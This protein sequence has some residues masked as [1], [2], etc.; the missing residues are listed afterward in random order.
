MARSPRSWVWMYVGLI[1]AACAAHGGDEAKTNQWWKL[2]VD[3]GL[4]NLR[5]PD[6]WVPLSI[7]AEASKA[8]QW[9]ALEEQ[10]WAL[11]ATVKRT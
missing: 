1:R 10:S 6:L 11:L 4:R 7:V 3:H 8:R 2:A 5:S 9:A